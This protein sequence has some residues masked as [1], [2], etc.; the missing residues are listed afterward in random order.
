MDDPELAATFQLRWQTLE[1]GAAVAAPGATL[2]PATS[3]AATLKAPSGRLPAGVELPRI[4]LDLH[5]GTDLHTPAPSGAPDLRVIGTLGEGGM[6]CV[7]LAHQ[8]SLA[9]DV[10]VKT[11]KPNADQRARAALLAEASISGSLEHPAIIPIHA[12]GV[13]DGGRPVLVMK[14]VEGTEWRQLIQDPAHPVWE[15]VPE[16]ADRLAAHLAILMQV[17]NAAHFAH[18]RGVAHRD[19]KPENV[20][21][22]RYGEVY[23]VDWG[24]ATRLDSQ[25]PGEL[26]GSPGYMAPEMVAGESVDA[27]TDVYLLGATLHEVLTGELRHAGTALYEVLLAAFRSEPHDYDDSVPE[28]LAGLCNRATRRD[29]TERPQSALELR[30]CLEAFLR[31]RDS[32]SLLEA[33]RRRLEELKALLATSPLSASLP[34]PAPAY[35]L[36]TECRFGLVQALTQWPESRAARGALIECIEAM[37]EVELR[38]GSL[39]A[40]AALLAELDSPPTKLVHR[41]EELRRDEAEREARDLRLRQLEHDL[42]DQVGARA[43]NRALLALGAVTL[44]ISAWALSRDKAELTTE[45][46]VVFGAMVFFVMLSGLAAYRRQVMVNAYNRRGAALVLIAGA[47]LLSSRVVGLVRDASTDQVFL[48]DLLLLTA[49]SALGTVMMGFWLWPIAL[50]YGVALVLGLLVPERLPVIFSAVSILAFALF[51]LVWRRR[52]HG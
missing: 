45:D 22:G 33:A 5:R 6:G 13:D 23:L 3:P 19:I 40:A 4:S 2:R 9:R 47:S 36:M 11:L 28:E 43:R 29:P 21:I 39:S 15:D 8:R 46:M 16:S 18:S 52:A 31:H 48:Q 35:R 51:I 20:M 10:A 14:R 50:S 17:C 26:V 44:G 7:H 12:L 37:V 27:R 1:L 34:D 41:L 24:V 25:Q 30:R 42:D 38:Q 49:L 32:V